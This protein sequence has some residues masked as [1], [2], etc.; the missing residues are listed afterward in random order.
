MTPFFQGRT[1]DRA[2]LE[3]ESADEVSPL[4][5]AGILKLSRIRIPAF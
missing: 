5:G 3:S 1:T 2:K 4:T